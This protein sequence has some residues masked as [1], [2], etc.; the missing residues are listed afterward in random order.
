MNIDCGCGPATGWERVARPARKARSQ[1]KTWIAWNRQGCPTDEPVVIRRG[2]LTACRHGYYLVAD[3][4]WDFRYM[5]DGADGRKDFRVG[6]VVDRYSG[7]YGVDRI[8]SLASCPDCATG[9]AR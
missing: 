4:H 8:R 6:M 2:S 1:V 9:G 7:R 3:W 5:P